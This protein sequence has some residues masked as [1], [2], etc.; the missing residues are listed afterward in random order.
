MELANVRWLLPQAINHKIYVI[1]PLDKD[2]GDAVMTA[3]ISNIGGYSI[4]DMY[5]KLK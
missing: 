3:Q 1:L 2:Q 5:T 4:S